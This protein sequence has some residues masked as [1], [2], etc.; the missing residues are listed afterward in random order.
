MTAIP[1]NDYGNTF[2]VE[3]CQQFDV[4][5]LVRS[6]IRQS[7]KLLI[8]SAIQAAGYQ[9]DLSETKTN[10]GGTRLWF[11]CPQCLGRKG[12]L[13]V[14]PVS[15]LLGCRQCLGVSYRSSRF[16]GMVELG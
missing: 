9:V 11:V 5:E 12:V 13:L 7:K 14:H 6:Y 16:K 8:E 10:F 4:N 3:N 1:P 2:T 15:N